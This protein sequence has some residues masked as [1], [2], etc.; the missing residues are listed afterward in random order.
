MSISFDPNLRRKL[1]D[2]RTARET[3]LV[4]VPLCDVFLP[5]T[6]EAEFL[7]GPGPAADWG[8]A[9]L[10]MGPKVV[11]LKCGGEGAIGF[12]A[13]RSV[14]AT[15]FPV[16]P[17]VDS[18]GAGDA[19]AAGFLSVYLDQPAQILEEEILEAAL[20]RGNLMGAMITQHRGDWEGLPTLAELH[21]VQSQ[22]GQPIANR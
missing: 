6:D 4:I 19:F 12:A 15:A 22:A 13:G 11:A 7:L 10:A 18:T 20:V 3:L 1:W 2:E 5:G 8:H 14:R 17:P 16:G 9:F 21:H